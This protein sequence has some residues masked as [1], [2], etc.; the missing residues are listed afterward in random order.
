ML[1]LG[2][3]C[4]EGRVNLK[5]FFFKKWKLIT[6][7]ATGIYLTGFDWGG[8]WRTK[9]GLGCLYSISGPIFGSEVTENFVKWS[10]YGENGICTWFRGAERPTK[11]IGQFWKKIIN[12]KAI[13]RGCMRYS[14]SG[15]LKI[16]GNW[17]VVQSPVI[18][19]QINPWYPIW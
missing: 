12:K 3:K 5:L 9:D 11:F 10:I 17:L 18:P 7:R 2:S 19:F 13:K 14:I 15:P 1:L 6:T 4:E 8:A 16:L